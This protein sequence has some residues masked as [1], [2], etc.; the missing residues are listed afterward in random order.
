[1]I[2]KNGVKNYASRE[3]ATNLPPYIPSEKSNEAAA[4]LLILKVLKLRV[5]SPPGTT[6]SI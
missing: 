1:M 4:P 5:L 3:S 2:S 6:D